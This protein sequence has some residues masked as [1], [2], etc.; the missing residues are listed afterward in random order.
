MELFFSPSEKL[1]ECEFALTALRLSLT[2]KYAIFP[3]DY[4]PDLP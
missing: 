3:S 1:A 2:P 4:I